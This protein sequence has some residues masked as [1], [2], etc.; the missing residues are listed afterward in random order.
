MFIHISSRLWI[1]G[2]YKVVYIFIYVYFLG[3]QTEWILALFSVNTRT[4]VNVS[5]LQ[6]K[7]SGTDFISIKSHLYNEPLM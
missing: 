3:K 5:I 1:L 2:V 7:R 4:D 6:K